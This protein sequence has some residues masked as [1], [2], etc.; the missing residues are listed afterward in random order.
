LVILISDYS[1]LLLLMLSILCFLGVEV[2]E[3]LFGVEQG[4]EM[5]H[6]INYLLINSQG[7]TIGIN[8]VAL[9]TIGMDLL[10]VGLDSLELFAQQN[11][12]HDLLG[13]RR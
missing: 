12:G 8:V 10:G 7:V 3:V 6:G 4:W 5:N 9:R 11:I 1:T 2:P 13:A